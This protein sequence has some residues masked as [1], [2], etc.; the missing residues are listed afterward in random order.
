[1]SKKKIQRGAWSEVRTV[2]DFHV[3]ACPTCS[4]SLV[5]TDAPPHPADPPPVDHAKMMRRHSKAH[6]WG[7]SVSLTPPFP[8]FH[9]RYGASVLPHV[10]IVPIHE[11][12]EKAAAPSRKETSEEIHL[13][14]LE[15]FRE[16]QRMHAR[17]VSVPTQDEPNPRRRAAATATRENPAV[18]LS[19]EDWAGL[20]VV[21][22]P[23][24][25]ETECFADRRLSNDEAAK[26]LRNPSAFL[27]QKGPYEDERVRLVHK[28]KEPRQGRGGR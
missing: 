12:A 9:S 25:T 5:L 8:Y 15:I 26:F 21:T 27:K 19:A 13:A 22:K 20:H 16:A 7:A 17:P 1:M 10:V 2:E 6:A 28:P 18:L 3:F 23:W 24:F 14:V 4:E 11:P